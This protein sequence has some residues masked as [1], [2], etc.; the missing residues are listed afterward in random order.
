MA[1]FRQAIVLG[2][3]EPGF[4]TLQ[5]GMG[6]SAADGQLVPHPTEP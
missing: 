1:A 5:A 2:R 4:T 3:G 6:D